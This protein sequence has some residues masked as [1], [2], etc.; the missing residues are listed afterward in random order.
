MIVFDLKCE[1]Q[2]HVF[3]AWFGSSADYAD[4]KARGLLA[5]PLCGDTRIGKAL[6][7]PAVA[8]KGNQRREIVQHQSAGEAETAPVAAGPDEAKMRALVE[9]LVDAQ[10][11]V[12]EGS[13]W[14]GRGFAEQARAMH[15]GEQDKGS[16]HGEVAPAEAK[17]LAEEGINVA[18]LPFPVIPPE[19]KN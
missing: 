9:A 18:Q 14:V 2:G 11:K 4:Q 12:L 17:A 7:A 13:T 16:I 19:A 8:A 5:C 6:M 3:E 10:K 1:G 15:Y